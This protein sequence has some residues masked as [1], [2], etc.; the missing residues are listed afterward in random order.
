M[1]HDRYF[2]NHL[3]EAMYTQTFGVHILIVFKKL[4][5]LGKF[6]PVLR[7]AYRL[8]WNRAR[9]FSQNWQSSWI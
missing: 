1:I 5:V 6:K 3:S 7:I 2:E 9:F 4:F 8:I